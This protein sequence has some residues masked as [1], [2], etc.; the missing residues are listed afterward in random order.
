MKN[1]KAE[2]KNEKSH[3]WCHQQYAAVAPS[4]RHRAILGLFCDENLLALLPAFRHVTPDHGIARVLVHQAE[5]VDITM[6]VDVAFEPAVCA[7]SACQIG[8][9]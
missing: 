5:K 9:N 2:Q 6:L 3:F 1:R 8:L 4:P 7:A